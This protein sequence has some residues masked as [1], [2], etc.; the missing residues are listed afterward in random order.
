MSQGFSQEELSQLT[1]HRS[2]IILMQAKAFQE[3]QKAQQSTKTKKK[4][5]TAKMV[6]SGTGG[7]KK[8]EKAKVKRTAQMKRLKESG[9]VNDSVSLF[10]DFVDI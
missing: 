1:D 6:K 3:M 7:K 2:L 10:E 9:H 8:G 4:V 5:K